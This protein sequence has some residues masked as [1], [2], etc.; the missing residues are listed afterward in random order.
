MNKYIITFGSNN[1]QKFAVNPM[2]VMLENLRITDEHIRSNR[3]KA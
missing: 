3:D 2:K 1:L